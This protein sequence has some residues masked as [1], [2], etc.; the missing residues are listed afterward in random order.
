MAA[1]L[2]DEVAVLRRR[3]DEALAERDEVQ[4][5]KD[6]IAEVLEV[7]N[8]SPGDLEAV[9]GAIL[10]KTVRLSD[11]AFGVLWT[12]DG[13]RLHRAALLDTPVAY[14]EYLGNAI[15]V[16]ESA[17]YAGIVKGQNF[18]HIPDLID[19]DSYRDG[20]EFRRATVDL[21]EARTGLAVPLRK[22]DG[23]LGI[24]AVFRKE[25]RPF[26]ERQIALV[27]NF[28]AQAAIAM[29][30]ARLITETREALEQQT[31]TS[32]ILRVIAR[33]PTDVQPVFDA[34][35]GSAARVCEAEF[36]AVARFDEALLHLVAVHS[37]S[38]EE[39][40]AFHRLFPRP[41]SRD[42]AMGRAFVDGLPVHFDDL[43][44]WGD[45][46][47]RTRKGLPGSRSFL[48]VPILREGRP[49]GVIGCGRREVK[50]FTDTQIEL[51]Q[52]FA[53]QA[54]IAIENIRLF[55]ELETRN[56]DVTEA[57]NQQTATAEVL[58][59]INSSPGDLHPVFD[60]MLAKA[61]RLCEAPL[62]YLLRRENGRLSLAAGRG[63]PPELVE[64]LANVDEPHGSEANARLLSGTPYVHIVDMKDEAYQAG[65]PLRRAAVD[66]GGARTGLA[67][68]LHRDDELLGTFNLARTELRPFTE[69][70]I[71]LTRNFAAQ[72]VIAIENTRLI[73]ETREALEQQTATAEVLQV[74][75]S[76]PG[77][78]APVFDAIL[79]KAHTLCGVAA[80]SLQINEGGKFR[81]VAMRGVPH[82]IAELLRRR[83]EP[84]SGAPAFRLL[85]GEPFIHIADMLESSRLRPDNPRAAMNA[86]YG[87]RTV[88]F[89]PLRKDRDLLGYISAYRLE[90]RAFTDKQ[91]ALLRNFAA[92]AVIAMENARLITETREAL[93]QQTAT[94]EVLGVINASPGDLTPVFDAM[95]ERAIWTYPGFV[96]R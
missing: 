95:L 29:E 3:L 80:G 12:Y 33:S 89:V 70:Q 64:Y 67:V 1:M 31:A 14:A 59:V 5:Q 91:I 40:A 30:N 13:E 81:A 65:A 52:T 75:N 82:P 41:P 17:V 45:Y 23:L 72:A 63:L 48:A 86:R 16:T 55:N 61:M 39:T 7:I 90:V 44:T 24:F 28:A 18:V 87:I 94:A 51:L 85:A 19:S 83:F 77:D 56:R 74:I 68:A 10:E 2:D 38:P 6:A 84:Q 8:G 22:S 79:E 25:V 42:F 71:A 93:E 78:L 9:F 11:A 57:L 66:L 60:A 92:Q 49:I 35:V 50:P 88:L 46:D 4:A 20:N 73:I 37:T 58:Q 47:Q 34:I 53:D 36:S 26:A 62:G 27:R 54:A 15:S 69:K 76:S 32:E 96:E 21:G 43:L